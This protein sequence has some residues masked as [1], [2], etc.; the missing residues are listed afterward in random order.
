MSHLADDRFWHN[1]KDCVIPPY[2]CGH[3][4]ETWTHFLLPC[5]N[6]HC[7]RQ[8]LFEKANKAIL[9]QNEQVIRKNFALWQWKSE[10]CS[11]R[12]YIDFHNRFPTGYWR[13][14]TVLCKIM[15]YVRLCPLYFCYFAFLSLKECTF[16]FRKNVLYLTS[17][18]LS[19]FQTLKL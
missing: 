7:A 12:L 17:K 10:S 6:N 4:I 8:I 9:K 15:F 16:E 1:F 11:K 5:P 3:R 13:F 14:K 18:A 19:F 2:S